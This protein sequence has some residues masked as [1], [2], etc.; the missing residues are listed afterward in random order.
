MEIDV[1]EFSKLLICPDLG[2]KDLFFG[3]LYFLSLDVD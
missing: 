1:Q 3:G 2:I